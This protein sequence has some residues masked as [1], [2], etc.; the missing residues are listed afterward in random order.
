MCERPPPLEGNRRSFARHQQP[1]TDGTR[2]ALKGGQR[3]KLVLPQLNR[4]H[5]AYTRNPVPPPA[6]SSSQDPHPNRPNPIPAQRRLTQQFTRHWLQFKA[7]LASALCRH[8]LQEQ[9]QLHLPQKHKATDQNSALRVEMNGLEDQADNA[10]ARDLYLK[11]SRGPSAQL[12]SMTLSTRRASTC[13]AHSGASKAHDWM[14]SELG[15]L[16]RTAGHTVRVLLRSARSRV[17]G[18]NTLT[19]TTFLS[20]GRC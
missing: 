11:P 5:E 10:K 12:Q 19:T 7:G 8:A 2:S 18:N 6:S 20:P 1:V 9:R 16:F 13:T 4:L 3:H 15:P 17:I 14:V